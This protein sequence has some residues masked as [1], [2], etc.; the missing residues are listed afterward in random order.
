MT[1]PRYQDVQS[2]DIPEVTD[3][4]G[5]KVRIIC[6]DFWGARGP[7][8]GVA[9]E[10][11]YLDVWVQPATTKR[12]PVDRSRNSFAYVFAGDGRFRNASEPRVVETE[13]VNAD[14][15]ASSEAVENRSLVV[16]DRG[17]EVVVEAGESG[18]RFLLVS[19]Q[20]LKEPIAW[21]GPIVM[22]TQAELRQAF[23]EYQA[24]TFL[25]H[26]GEQP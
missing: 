3:D 10:P 21:Q 11:Q 9:A 18:I 7:I 15:S 19:G 26:Q 17:D 13:A 12:L 20:P 23:A 24:G 6:G 2:A 22:N 16:F 5:T 14:G 4:D 25:K 1:D 8:D